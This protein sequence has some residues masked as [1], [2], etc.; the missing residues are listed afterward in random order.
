MNWLPRTLRTAC[1][2][3]L[4]LL[5]VSG[6]VQ[7]GAA[8]PTAPAD[9]AKVERQVMDQVTG[10][11]TATF[12]VQLRDRADLGGVTA[13][14]ARADRSRYVYQQLTAT[15]SRSQD[16]LRRLLTARGAR[17]QQ[18]WIANVVLV[19]GGESLLT[20]IA[21]L[22]EVVRVVPNRQHQI[23]TPSPVE[24]QAVINAIEWNI[25]RI[26]APQVWSTFGTRGEGMVVANIDTGVQFD[27]PALVRQYR[28]NTGSGFNH[29]FSWFDPTGTCVAS[30]C[31]NNGHGT[32]T[33]GTMVGDDGAGN[34]IGVA[35]GA[36]WI[37]AKGCAS[38]SCSNAALLSAGQWVVAPTDLNGQNPRP[39]LSPDVVNNSWG[40]NPD[41][42]FYRDTVNAWI[43]AGIF[44]AF[45]NCN[46]GSACNTS[47][48][49]GDY[50]ESYAVGAFDINN[51]IASFS[52]RGPGIGTELKPN[53]SAPGV[54][55]RSSVPTN[56]FQ[57]FSGT[58]MAT[59][60]VAGSIA[61]LWAVA[62]ALRGDVAATRQVL[63]GTAI[64]VSN[65]TCGGTAADNNVW[66][67]GR[68]DIF[69]A[70]QRA[71]GG[72]QSSISGTVTSNGLAVAGTAV[73]L[74][75]GARVTTT[76][77]NGTYAFTGL[78]SGAFTVSAGGTRCLG[79]VSRSV[80]VSGAVTV[81]LALPA[82]S[83]SFGNTCVDGSGAFVATSTLLSLTGDDAT[84]RVTLPFGFRFYGQTF[85][86]AFVS[87]NGLVSFPAAS[88]A[89]GN[90]S[91]PS[92]AA[93]NG[94]VYAYWDDLFVDSSASVR[95]ATVGAAPNRQ[96]VIEWRNVRFFND[97]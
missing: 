45:A 6:P 29:N 4:G 81:N 11:G 55:V 59:P 56:S 61:L 23:P 78:A 91:I 77:A 20:E 85:T 42:T 47:G 75:P 43:S 65:T 9:A 50:P 72:Q 28:G 14:R 69:A 21:A 49:P 94:A 95:T 10:G 39:D 2:L 19:T 7:A 41:D 70:A 83:D 92:T 76:A 64:D 71:S 67:E 26:G 5:V 53:V 31:D 82:R 97:T 3:A 25:D 79:A 88:T 60:H 54:S 68:L 22:P 34:Q 86:S 16:G 51:A 15:A 18:F 66:G 90:T 87:T 35:P 84:A 63:D 40:G 57:A 13:V 74:N 17:F 52:S 1:G 36:R 24:A 62:P 48:S 37:A 93:P 44:P 96:F 80:N 89:F 58:S 12:F 38:N 32:H 8:P 30:P 73:T 27:H 33:M 46:A